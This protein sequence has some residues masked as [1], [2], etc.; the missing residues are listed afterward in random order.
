VAL[1]RVWLPSPNY[2]G[3]SGARVSTIVLH[4]AEGALTY[5]SLGN[6]FSSPSAGVSSH[7]GIDDTPGTVGEY[8]RRDYKAWTAANANPWAVQ[9]ELCAFAAWDA[10]EW[11]R[12]PQMLRN[13]ADWIAEEAAA[14]GIPLDRLSPA[15]AQNPGVPGVCQHADLGAMGG[16]HWDCGPG[17]PIDRVLDMARGGIAPEPEPEPEPERGDDMNVTICAAHDDG[18]QY[19]TDLCTFKRP[20]AGEDDWNSTVFCLVASGVKVYYNP[21]VNNPVRVPAETL[22][23]L[24]EIR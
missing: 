16:G 13:T 18:R 7:A 21:D 20:I 5:Q 14:H 23:G 24:P 17:F 1:N 9:A 12:H 6:F 19:V 2:S 11:D 10:A 22:A 3:R 15:D 8:V 4:T